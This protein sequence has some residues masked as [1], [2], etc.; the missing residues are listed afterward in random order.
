MGSRL[1]VDSPFRIDVEV[2]SDINGDVVILCRMVK[3]HLEEFVR[4]LKRALNSR[5]IYEWLTDTPPAS[6]IDT[7]TQWV[8]RFYYPQKLGF[9]GKVQGRTFGIGQ[10]RCPG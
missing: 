4:Q 1:G 9:G 7:D 3:H 6:L 8:A 10:H 5:Q 2:I